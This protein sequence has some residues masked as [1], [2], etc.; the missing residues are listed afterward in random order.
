MAFLEKIFGAVSPRAFAVRL[1]DG[2]ML[3]AS[4]GQATHFTL[5]IQHPGALRRM[6]WSPTELSLGEAYVY[7]DY[8]IEGDV[9]MA[10]SVGLGLLGKARAWGEILRLRS[11]LMRLPAAGPPHV[12]LAPQLRGK[13]HSQAR[14]RCAV[15]YHY[16]VSN[17]FYSLFL[18]QR[19]IYSCARFAGPQ[20]DLDKAQQRKLENI[21]RALRLQPGERFL[22]IGC[23]WGGLI[24]YAAQ[25]FGVKALGIT[26]SERQAEW[27]R[28]RVRQAGLESRCRVE[29]L[30][31]RDLKEVAAFDK[32]ASIGMVEH[33]GAKQLPRYFERI[34]RLLRPGGAFLNSGISRPVS[35]PSHR[36]ASFTDTYV[37]PDGEL[38]PVSE[39]LAEAETAG[40][41]VRASENLR[42][43]YGLTLRHWV[44]RLEKHAEEACRIIDPRTYRVWRLYMAGSAAR[45][46]AGSL[47]VFETLLTR[48]GEGHGPLA[49]SRWPADAEG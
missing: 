39:M 9:E 41:E 7:D 30:D 37:F 14:D 22:D 45:F 26:L 47:H 18:D 40:F 23:G 42:E 25:N 44:R 29:N 1:W 11:L 27:A 46:F 15:R 48:T 21:C 31:Y 4:P 28:E 10:L 34:K 6:F 32:V 33:V 24:L 43:Q 13:V 38:E 36:P 16:D 12:S 3:P 2:T 17:E 35:E 8:D 5:R 20:E 19:M 49:A